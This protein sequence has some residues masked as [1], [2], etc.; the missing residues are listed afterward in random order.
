MMDVIHTDGQRTH[1]EDNVI[2]FQ[3]GPARLGYGVLGQSDRHAAAL[4]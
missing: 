1:R 2:T 4:M 3:P